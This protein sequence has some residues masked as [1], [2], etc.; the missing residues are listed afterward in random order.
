MAR[1]VLIVK[2]AA[3][4]DV[5]MALP[6][7]TAL[8]AADPLTRIVWMCGV[9]VAPLLACIEGIDETIVVDETAILTGSH[10]AKAGVVA[11]A[12]SRLASH[13]FDA[14]YVAHSDARYLTLVK[15]ARAATLRFLG[16]AGRRPALVP[17]RAYSDEY[18]RLVTGL[19]DHR[20]P[21]FAL[22]AIRTSLPAA[23][24]ARLDALDG[25]SLIALAPGGAKN[26]ARDNPLRRWPTDRYAE[27]AR[28]LDD[29][30]LAV[31]ITGGAT[32]EWVRSHFIGTPVLDLIGATDLPGLVAL[33]GRCTAVV[34]HDSGPMHLARLAKAPLIALF[35]PTLPS[36]FLR[37]DSTTRILWPGAALPCAPCYDGREFA[38]CDDNRC[39][40]LIMVDD[41]LASLRK[42]LALRA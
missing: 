6:M 2:L 4:G 21:R 12:W 31:A 18:V 41:V 28:Q 26:P 3:I 30:G 11:S 19:D 9:E 38:A 39:M 22:P 35:G 24:S 25:R 34:T 29:E 37:E 16:E 32:D 10:L 20:A 17:G 42:L 15:T 40:Q 13:R 5:A 14:I 23:L 27:L 7:V 33:Y 36:A 8:R 1:T